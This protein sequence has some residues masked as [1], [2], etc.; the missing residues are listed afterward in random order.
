MFLIPLLLSCD[1]QPTLNFS[2]YS[3]ADRSIKNVKSVENVK[4]SKVDSIEEREIKQEIKRLK[5]VNI[6]SFEEIDEIERS[7]DQYNLIIILTEIGSTS[8]EKAVGKFKK[9]LSKEAVK[10][11]DEN[12]SLNNTVTNQ[13]ILHKD[14][15]IEFAFAFVKEGRYISNNAK[16]A[17]VMREVEL[18][19]S[20][21][22][23]VLLILN[24]QV[25]RNTL[26]LEKL[27]PSIED[28]FNYFDIAIPKKEYKYIEGKIKHKS[29][30]KFK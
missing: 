19:S 4:N 11:L 7:I 28:K 3:T 26:F 29:D 22:R 16:T 23:R 17:V 21:N 30:F 25:S 14:R 24:G 18:T 6:W 2:S 15:D 27:I 10:T 12:I 8:V 20:S 5:S 9:L 13:T 1:I